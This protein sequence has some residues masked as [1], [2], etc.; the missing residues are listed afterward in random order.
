MDVDDPIQFHQDRDLGL[1]P[2]S[3]S[4]RRRLT[5]AGPSRLI[6]KTSV[7]QAD[8]FS[9]EGSRRDGAHEGINPDLRRGQLR[10]RRRLHLLGL[11]KAKTQTISGKSKRYL[12]SCRFPRRYMANEQDTPYLG[13]GFG[14]VDVYRDENSRIGLNSGCE[15]SST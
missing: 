3:L 12:H 2:G 4:G 5:L 1:D 10:P 7:S 6:L 13:D 11:E 9:S 14:G 15:T 8:S